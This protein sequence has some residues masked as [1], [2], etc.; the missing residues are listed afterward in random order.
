MHRDAPRCT[1]EHGRAEA[2]SG[3][4]VTSWLTLVVELDYLPVVEDGEV[5]VVRRR[6]LPVCQQYFMRSLSQLRRWITNDIGWAKW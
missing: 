6:D 4:D 5:Q 3:K 1:T 2:E